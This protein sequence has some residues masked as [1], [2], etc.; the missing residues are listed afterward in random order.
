[1][2][3]A[4]LWEE[5]ARK[6]REVAQAIANA[7]A[8]VCASMAAVNM[9]GA[10]FVADPKLAAKMAADSVLWQMRATLAHAGIDPARLTDEPTST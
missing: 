8:S 9:T 6:K 2:M 4:M 10:I 3:D 7:R 1:M 5:S